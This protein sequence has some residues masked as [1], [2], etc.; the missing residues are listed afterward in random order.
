M[1]LPKGMTIHFDPEEFS[2]KMDEQMLERLN[3]DMLDLVNV[4]LW[5]WPAFKDDPARTYEVVIDEVAEMV[6]G[7]ITD[8]RATELSESADQVVD[9][10]TRIYTHLEPTIQDLPNQLYDSVISGLRSDLDSGIMHVLRDFP[11]GKAL[12]LSMD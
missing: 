5:T 8:H 9:L 1:N 7:D 10:C 4:V 11:T 3:L 6:M 2:G 12:L